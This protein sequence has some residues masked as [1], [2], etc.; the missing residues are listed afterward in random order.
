MLWL[1]SV[2]KTFAGHTLFWGKVSC[3]PS[4]SSDLRQSLPARSRYSKF[5]PWLQ[6]LLKEIALVDE[7][8]KRY[9]AAYKALEK[10]LVLALNAEDPLFKMTF[11]ALHPTGSSFEGLRIDDPNE[12]DMN[13]VLNLPL[14]KKDDV[15]V[16]EDE[17]AGHMKVICKKPVDS[18]YDEPWFSNQV[19]QKGEEKNLNIIRSNLRKWWNGSYLSREKVLRWMQSAVDRALVSMNSQKSLPLWRIIKSISRKL[20]GPAVTLEV[21]THNGD[22]FSVD[23]VPALVFHEDTL[24]QPIKDRVKA[25]AKKRRD[26]YLIP[27]GPAESAAKVWRASLWDHEKDYISGLEHFKPL[28]RLL[29]RLRDE[30]NWPGLASYYVKTAIMF[31]VEDVQDGGRGYFKRSIGDLI[32]RGLKQ[33]Q[34]VTTA[35]NIPFFWDEGHNLLEKMNRDTCQNMSK[36]L[37]VVFK[38]FEKSLTDDKEDP[39]VYF[40]T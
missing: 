8:R 26:W 1:T 33:L 3:S 11:S 35:C 20:S 23:F 36:R 14:A 17:S 9:N 6:K 21:C 19:K 38:S 29:K 30:Q 2:A 24:P 34:D 4:I 5:D 32:M 10:D 12:F 13:A 37:N 28:V 22:Y 27:K 7:E 16:Q 39:M 25:I 18:Y 31:I 40:G 15:E